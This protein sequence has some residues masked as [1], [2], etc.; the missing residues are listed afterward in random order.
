[1]DWAG[2]GLGGRKWSFG[3]RVCVGIVGFGDVVVGLV[4][5]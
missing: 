4:G 2:F 5:G 3:S 1:M